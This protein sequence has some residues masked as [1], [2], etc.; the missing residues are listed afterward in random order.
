MSSSKDTSRAALVLVILL[1]GIGLA[2]S[3]IDLSRQESQSVTTCSHPEEMKQVAGSTVSVH[4]RENGA[5]PEEGSRQ[6]L[7]GPARLLYG[8]KLD[9][10]RANAAAFE[11]LPRIGPAR[12]VAI[13]QHR[14]K[15]P[16]QSVDD[17]RNVSGIGPVTMKGLRPY[18]MVRE[19]ETDESG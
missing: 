18:L 11:A 12:A 5:F 2:D 6:A 9:L 10:N 15:Q 16:F 4:C 7:R 13:L 17:V 3:R 19:G 1:Q 14:K 8:L